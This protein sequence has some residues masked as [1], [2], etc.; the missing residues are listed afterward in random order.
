EHVAEAVGVVDVVHRHGAARHLPRSL[1]A[2]H[3][4]VD[5]LDDL[6]GAVDE[7][8]GA[9]AGQD[10]DI[11]V[12]VDGADHVPVQPLLAIAEVDE[13]GVAFHQDVYVFRHRVHVHVQ[14][15]GLGA[16]AGG[17]RR[18]RLRGRRRMDVDVVD[19][20]RVGVAERGVDV[21]LGVRAGVDVLDA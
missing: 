13:G 21:R 6:P 5:R 2:V 10:D 16:A 20:N 14:G 1:A 19:G 12:P 17:H 15:A 4:D 7:Q 18:A 3:G 11:G 8:L 9:R